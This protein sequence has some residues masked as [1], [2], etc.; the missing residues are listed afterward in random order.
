MAGDPLAIPLLLGLGI[1][2][3]SLAAAR[4]PLAKQVVRATDL[5][6][7][8]RLAARALAAGSAAEVRELNRH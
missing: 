3:L 1:T 2:G 6:A 5:H 8:R 4:I 7:A